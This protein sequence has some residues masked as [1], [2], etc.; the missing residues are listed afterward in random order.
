M[1]S[2]IPTSEEI[3]ELMKKEKHLTDEKIQEILALRYQHPE[4][5]GKRDDLEENISAASNILDIDF[6]IL[7]ATVQICNFREPQHLSALRRCMD[8]ICDMTPEEA[9]EI[10]K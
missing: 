3:A 1:K 9:E 8:L 10:G 7:S 4:Y 6:A 5:I 2:T